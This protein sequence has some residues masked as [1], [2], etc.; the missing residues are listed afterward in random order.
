M[1]LTERLTPSMEL[2]LQHFIYLMTLFMSLSIFLANEPT[3][4]IISD[5]KLNQNF[6][7][8]YMAIASILL[9]V[10]LHRQRISQHILLLS[11]LYMGIV[12]ANLIYSH[13]NAFQYLIFISN[14]FFPILLSEYRMDPAWF[15]KFFKRFLTVFNVLTYTLVLTGLI[16]YLTNSSIQ[17]FFATHGIF[18]REWSELVLIEHKMGIYRYYSL[19]GHPLVNSWYFL[20]YFTLNFLNNKYLE[21]GANKFVMAGVTLLGLVLSGS[22]TAMILGLVLVLMY[23]KVTRYKGVFY[24]GLGLFMVGLFFSPVFQENLLKRYTIGIQKGDFGEGRGKALSYVLNGWI[25]PPHWILGGGAGYSREIVQ[26]MG[27]INSF[28]YPSI[29]FMYDF[30]IIGTIILYSIIFICP[31]IGF[32]KRKHVHIAFLFCVSSL[33]MNGFNAISNYTDY[34]GQLCVFIFLLTN[35]SRYIHERDQGK[36]VPEGGST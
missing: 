18:N 26:E 3:R 33:Y 32:I 36:W 6:N 5:N 21:P 34:M 31:L 4:T 20:I 16:D 1:D 23:T 14:M 8:A 27:F 25:D 10:L 28:E 12:I 30:S 22:K 24:P 17:L 2:R 11:V 29:M 15:I 35:I 9:F 7:I 13:R 19:V